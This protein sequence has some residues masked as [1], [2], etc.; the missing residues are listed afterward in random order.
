MRVYDLIFEIGKRDFVRVLDGW[1]WW[2][3]IYHNFIRV[4][5]CFTAGL[6]S[7]LFMRDR[8]FKASV[9][10]RRKPP[11]RLECVEEATKRG[12]TESAGSNILAKIRLAFEEHR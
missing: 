9:Q 6:H 10:V 1:R 3:V 7:W 5:L 12:R 8:R 2:V 11:V 4:T